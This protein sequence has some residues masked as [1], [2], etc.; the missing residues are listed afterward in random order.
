MQIIDHNWSWSGAL[1]RRTATDAIVLHHAA[2]VSASTE[3]IDRIHKGNNWS[4]IGYHY[5]VRKN[6]EVHRGR[7]EWAIGAHVL[8]HNGHTI[9]VCAEG[10]YETETAMPAAQ[11]AALRELV[12]DLRKRYPAAQVKRHSDYMAT[13]CPGR[14]YPFETI[15]KYEEEEEMSYEKYCE[16]RQR[17]D[18]EL[19]E[20]TASGWAA[21][22][23]RN[24][25][26]S[27]LFSDGDGDGTLDNPRAP[28]TREQFAAVLD[29]A[30]ILAAADKFIR[31]YD[32]LPAW[33][34]PTIRELLD[35][36]TIN[37]GTADDPDDINM[38][39]SDIKV[40]CVVKRMIDAD[41]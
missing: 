28:V 40:I 33:A 23:A 36:G 3:D 18:A 25:I 5:Y 1:P 17:Y 14:Y 11:L 12:A 10:N 29:R 19:A 35:N 31:R 2:A 34:Q 26:L 27:G 24:A 41:K 20:K 21:E 8:E 9:G 6:G 22:N 7:P 4:G 30:G 37:G 16:Y 38:Y 15:T 32:E 39:L 13:A